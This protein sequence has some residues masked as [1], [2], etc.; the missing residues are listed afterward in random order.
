MDLF[1]AVFA[2]NFIDEVGA[3]GMFHPFLLMTTMASRGRRMSLSPLCLRMGCHIRNVPVAA[4]AGV[5]S[6]SR[7]DEFSFIDLVTVATE[8]F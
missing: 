2:L 4:N 8:T 6:M 5:G 1:M 3:P 7:L